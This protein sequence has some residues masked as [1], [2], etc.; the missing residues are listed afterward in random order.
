M[1]NEGLKQGAID[2]LKI[3]GES[4][5]YRSTVTGQFSVINATIE[6]DISTVDDHGMITRGLVMNINPDDLGDLPRRG[7]TATDGRG[8]QY[9]IDE[10]LDSPGYLT[11][12]FVSPS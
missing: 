6:Q 1:R 2:W 8:K 5:Q 10:V 11:R 12:V 4:V 7:D 9:R 3:T